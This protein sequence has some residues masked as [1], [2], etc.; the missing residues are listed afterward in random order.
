MTMIDQRI[1]DE[2]DAE[3]AFFDEA[4]VTRVRGEL[5]AGTYDKAGHKLDV[6]VDRLAD[7]L[8][9]A[10]KPEVPALPAEFACADPDGLG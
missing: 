8:L 4:T 6:A 5:A 7:E 3:V 1:C 9:A 2:M 10:G